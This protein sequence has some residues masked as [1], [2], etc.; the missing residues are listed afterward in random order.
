MAISMILLVLAFIAPWY[1]FVSTF[2][3]SYSDI[4][5][6]F[7]DRFYVDNWQREFSVPPLT[8]TLDYDEDVGTWE[9]LGDVMMVEIVLLLAAVAA[10]GAAA[11]AVI[12]LYFYLMVPRAVAES[13]PGLY[14]VVE[15]ERF[16]GEWKVS[17]STFNWGPM[18]GWYLVIAAA[19]L[20]FAAL[21]LLSSRG[22]R[23]PQIY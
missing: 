3:S 18:V 2:P 13:V 1:H 17:T 16:W 10:T 6:V 20:E 14:S 12:V 23:G 7:E 22:D 9:A 19:F 15:L 11:A 4:G 21:A 8:T 5:V